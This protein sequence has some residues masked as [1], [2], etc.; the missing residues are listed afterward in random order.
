MRMKSYFILLALCSLLS[1]I[2][3]N[4]TSLF[5]IGN[6]TVAASSSMQLQQ[7]LPCN[8]CTFT[9]V[10]TSSSYPHTCS[11]QDCNGYVD[12]IDELPT[13]SGRDGIE[14]ER[15]QCKGYVNGEETDC[16]E[17]DSYSK[18]SDLC[19][20]TGQTIGFFACDSGSGGDGICRFRNNECGVSNCQTAGQQCA[21]DAGLYNPHLECGGNGLCTLVYTCGTNQC[22]TQNACCVG[23]Y[24]PHYE[25]EGGTCI[26]VN[27]CG[28][29]QCLP[30]QSCGG[31][32]CSPAYV[33]WCYDTMGWLDAFCVCHWNTPILIDVLGNG[34]A[35]TNAA[36]GVNFDL[37]PGGS[38]E[39]LGWTTAGS[40]DAFLA[41]DRNN[42][43]RIDNG[44]ELF[45]DYTPQSRPPNGVPKNGFLAL[46]EYD[47]QVNGGN[48]DGQIDSRDRLFDSLRLWQDVNHN[49]VSEIGELRTLPALGVDS[50]ELNY[51]ESKKTDEYG[52][53][54]RYRA[55]V[56]DA[57]HSPVGRWAWDV[58]LV[59]GN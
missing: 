35:L 51:R 59:K 18:V 32:G 33:Y 55:K 40:D 39:R 43:G 46:A 12:R 17:V 6:A 49:G 42:N 7:C 31:G 37:Q 8:T 20:P 1:F 27:T 41:T 45:G 3:M 2:V 29:D 23:L 50:I 38:L 44:A 26:W 58:I 54:F 53:R 13:G 15:K 25:C 22:S 14:M 19:C 48:G 9:G 11:A 5:V 36:N 24:A 4:A 16:G 21:C 28:T 10:S 47:K 57:R 30:N 56:D 52:N 34:F